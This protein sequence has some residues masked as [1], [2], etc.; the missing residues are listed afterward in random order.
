MPKLPQTINVEMNDDGM[1]KKLFIDGEEFPW[2]LVAH[3]TVSTGVET[4]MPTVTVTI[5]AHLITMTGPNKQFV[6]PTHDGSY[7]EGPEND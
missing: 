5:P 1:P 4:A 2:H 7:A 6:F 3:I